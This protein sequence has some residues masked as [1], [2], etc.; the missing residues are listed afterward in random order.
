MQ[1][2]GLNCQ[3][4]LFRDNSR[5]KNRQ[6]LLAGGAWHTR[7]RDA[8]EDTRINWQQ[9]QTI[10]NEYLL[11]LLK[12]KKAWFTYNGVLFRITLL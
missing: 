6:S 7:G 8:S 3:I 2:F 5:P 11:S 4:I 10:H 9:Y 1:V 12:E